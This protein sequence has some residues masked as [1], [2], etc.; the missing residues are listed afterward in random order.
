M[1]RRKH[2]SPCF[3]NL[4]WS[5]RTNQVY[6]L[7][8]N[9]SCYHDV[10]LTKAEVLQHERESKT[11]RDSGFHAMDSG[12]Q[13]LDS[14]FLVSGTWIPDSLRCIFRVPKPRIPDSTTKNC[15]IPDSTSQNFPDSGIRNPLVGREVTLSGNLRTKQEYILYSELSST[16]WTLHRKIFWR[17]YWYSK[18]MW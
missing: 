1:K 18:M 8:L 3:K 15:W 6:W 12:F 5:L 10:V 4:F 9:W 16:I 2:E 13:V 11:V 17:K 7:T 14:G